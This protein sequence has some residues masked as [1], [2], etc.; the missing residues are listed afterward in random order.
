MRRLH[1][2]ILVATLA[3]VGFVA[4]VHTQGGQRAW[5]PNLPTVDQGEVQVVPVRGNV[6][7][8]VGAG[9][10][11]TM[12]VGPDGVLIVDTG[13]A[14]MSDKVIAAIRSITNEPLRYIVNT[15]DFDEHTGANQTLAAAGET[16]PFRLLETGGGGGG[17]V[18]GDLDP[19]RATVISYLSILDR[20]SAPA[21]SNSARPEGAWPDNTYS[22]PQKELYFNNEPIVIIHRPGNT[23]GNSIVHFR[24][25]DVVS[26]GDLVDLTNYPRIDIEAGGNVQAL[27]D[28][29]FQLT[30]LTVVGRKSEGGTLIVPGHGRLADQPDAVYYL[31]MVAIVRDRVQDMMKRG[32]TLEQIQTARPTRE[33]DTRYGRD[34]RWT[35]AMFVEAVYQ[36]LM[37]SAK[38]TAS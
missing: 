14:S 2:S 19:K 25:A 34:T 9:V 21:G 31:Q 28:S 30:D 33:Y 12:Q 22:T 27:L 20:M 6:Y 26:V 36:S 29:L 4:S 16:I 3:L 10:N 8:I 37:K 7:M 1:T 15:V 5:R 23:D 38:E 32:M 35:A 11:I 18:G 24:T 17:R 13:M